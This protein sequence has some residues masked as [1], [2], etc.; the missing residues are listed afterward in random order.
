VSAVR[1]AATGVVAALAAATLALTAGCAGDGSGG[2]AGGGQGAAGSEHAARSRA[3]TPPPTRDADGTDGTGKKAEEKSGRKKNEQNE[4]NE[5]NEKNGDKDRAA[6]K[7]P[8]SQL[9]PG[10]GSFTKKEKKYLVDRV[11]KGLEP[12]AVL[13]AG[14]TACT[15]L[16][17]TAEASK[18]DAISALKAGEIDNAE[19]AVEHLCPKYKPLLE[20][21]GK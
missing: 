2:K 1:A 16:R 13:E 12:A 17:T 5:R 3:S 11:P 6:P 14:E 4:Q 7:V 18:K 20:A 15:R 9:T 10:T 19:P 21:A 8:R